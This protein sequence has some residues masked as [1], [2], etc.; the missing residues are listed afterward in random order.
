MPLDLK[1]QRLD[2]D[3]GLVALA[4]GLPIVV[5]PMLVKPREVLLV[6]DS[7]GREVV[8]VYSMTTFLYALR[9]ITFHTDDDHDHC[10]TCTPAGC[11]CDVEEGR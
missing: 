5:R 10:R 2:I 7:A 6:N 4:Q 3:P 11:R 9:G 8:L 1:V